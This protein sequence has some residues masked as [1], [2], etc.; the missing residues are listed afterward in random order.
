LVDENRRIEMGNGR[1]AKAK[2]YRGEV[3]VLGMLAEILAEEY[4]KAGLGPAPE[5]SRSPHGRD[6]RGVNWLALEV[7]RH[8]PS[9]GYSDV[10]LQQI[11]GWWEQAKSQARADQEPILI[12]RANFQPWRVRMFGKLHTERAAVRAP[13]DI[14]I[15]AFSIWFRTKVREQLTPAPSESKPA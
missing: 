7:K 10:T 15:E 3:E 11:K 2:G 12:Y 4:A 13:V 5:L 14:G 9:V 6:I 8:E 1:S